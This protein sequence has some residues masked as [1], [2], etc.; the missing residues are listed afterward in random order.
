M[1]RAKAEN[2]KKFINICMRVLAVTTFL[3]F[4]LSPFSGKLTIYKINNPADDDTGR[5]IIIAAQHS[6]GT[7]ARAGG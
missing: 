1:R 4:F 6:D 3:F 5:I 2:L 7:S